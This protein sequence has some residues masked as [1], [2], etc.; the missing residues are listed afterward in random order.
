M[1]VT[2]EGKEYGMKYG[3]SALKNLM[4]KHKLKRFGEIALIPEKLEMSDMP[5]F[6]KA[7][8]DTWAKTIGEEPP[9]TEKE[10]E[11]LL[12]EHVWLELVAIEAFTA[13]IERPQSGEEPKG[14]SETDK[15]EEPGN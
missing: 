6:V 11:E 14:E 13:S 8:F 9:F 4:H 1:I 7:G 2:I 12:E 5:D 10:I 15:S 3:H